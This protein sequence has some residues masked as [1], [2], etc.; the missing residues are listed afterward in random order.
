MAPCFDCSAASIRQ[1]SI[2]MSCVADENP[3]MKAKSAIRP[4]LTV[5]SEPAM[6]QRPKMM[7]AWHTSIQERRWPSHPVSSGTC[8]RSMN[9]AQRNLNDEISVTR[10]KNP[11]TSS[12]RPDARNQA[13]SVSKMRKYGSAAANPR[14]IITSDARSV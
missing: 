1:A 14:A 2:A 9:G 7:A 3:T 4:R 10:L 13:E 11:I 6:S 8:E 5:G 12:E